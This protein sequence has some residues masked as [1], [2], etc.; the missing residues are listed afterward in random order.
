[1]IIRAARR[2]DAPA[3]ARVHVDSWRTTY[4]GIIADDLLSRLSYERRE[5]QWTRALGN[6]D[7]NV[8]YVAEE[9][10]QGVIGFA[11][12]GPENTGDPVYRGELYAIYLL[13]AHQRKGLGRRLIGSIAERLAQAGMRSML[14]WVLA[15]NLAARR[16]Y[17]SL[18]GEEV[19]EQQ[20]DIGGTKYDEVAYGWRDTRVLSAIP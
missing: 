9:G 5:Q 16:F 2:E 1:M 19:R 12:G 14:L 7:V 3:I 10:S 4:R 11:A 15:G 6:P 18:G 17:E 13:E 20:I 8:L